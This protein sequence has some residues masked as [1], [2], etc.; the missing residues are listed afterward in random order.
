MKYAE[1][2]PDER[3]IPIYL[4]DTSGNPVTGVVFAAGDIRVSKSG[5]AMADYAG[6]WTEVGGGLYYYEATQLEVTTPSF[7]M[8]AVTGTG[9]KKIV[10]T[11]GIGERISINNADP[12][13]RR[14]P[15]YLED[16]TGAGVPG[17]ALAGLSAFGKNGAAYVAPSGAFGEIEN[18]AYY[19]ELTLAEI[20]TAGFGV[21]SILDPSILDFVYTWN[22][23]DPGVG[24]IT[25]SNVAPVPLQPVLPQDAIQFDITTPVGF[26]LILP[27]ISLNPF[28]VP[29]IVH[30]GTDFV[31]L[32]IEGSTR[33]AIVDGYRYTIRRKRGWYAQPNLIIHAVDAAGGV[34]VGP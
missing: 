12:L 9:A 1:P 19:Y 26:A 4:E 32:Y 14:I 2:N 28:T 17:L 34:W 7:V 30:D 18:G 8:L 33:V 25:V 29:E 13:A 21:L 10:Y 31:P 15:I 22:V 5:A 23:I 3:R 6:T 16:S 11:V 20:D 27:T 24:T